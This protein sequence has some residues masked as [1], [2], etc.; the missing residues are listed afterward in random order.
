VGGMVPGGGAGPR[1]RLEL[2]D[3]CIIELPKIV[4][5][6]GNLTFIESERHVPFPLRR[7]F[8]L[9]DVPGGA[10]RAGHALKTCH[11]LRHLEA[12]NARRRRLAARYEEGFIVDAAV[13]CEGAAPGWGAE[14]GDRAD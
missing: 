8:Y 13:N 14:R 4:D 10:L 5:P 9:Y 2:V 6:R 7:V 1:W 12:W 11:K 3:C